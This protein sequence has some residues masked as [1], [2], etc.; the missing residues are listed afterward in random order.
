MENPLD[1]AGNVV[2][3]SGEYG[4]QFLFGIAR[5]LEALTGDATTAAIFTGFLLFTLALVGK[6]GTSKNTELYSKSLMGVCLVGSV[7]IVIIAL[8]S[9]YGIATKTN[10]TK[11]VGLI[12]QYKAF[13]N[14]EWGGFYLDEYLHAVGYTFG[15]YKWYLF[16][17]V[18]VFIVGFLSF[19]VQKI[20]RKMV[21]KEPF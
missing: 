18:V 21:D 6:V 1:T 17:L 8:I 13:T 12:I 4:S 3:N 19:L 20:N 16:V 15:K 5:Y 10:V 14:R 7:L 2:K 11:D 9:G